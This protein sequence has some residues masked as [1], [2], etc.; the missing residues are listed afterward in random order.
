M[1]RMHIEFQFSKGV[2]GVRI[3]TPPLLTFGFM[4][5]QTTDPSS[6]IFHDSTNPLFCE[7]ACATSLLLYLDM[8]MWCLARYLFL[9]LEFDNQDDEKNLFSFEVVLPCK[10]T[11]QWIE[12]TLDEGFHVVSFQML[13]NICTT[14]MMNKYIL[15]PYF[16]NYVLR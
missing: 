7:F 10:I 8:E 2:R 11:R 5:F 9:S 1:Q 15:V 14:D 13:T 16:T 12:I 3:L 6:K 4:L